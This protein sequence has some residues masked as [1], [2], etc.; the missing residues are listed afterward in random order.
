M[1][2]A[3]GIGCPVI[4]SIT[5]ATAVLV[6]TEPTLSGI[7]DMKRVVDL[8]AHFHI[9]VFVCINKFD[10]NPDLTSRVESY[11]REGRLKLA[12]KI[13]YDNVVT[14]AMVQGK[15]VVE[16]SSGVVAKEIEKLWRQI[17]YHL[18]EG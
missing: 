14:K 18:S 4:S 13:P 11:C 5:G 17:S 16:Y 3:P 10:L 9:P 1:D 2:G 7:H 6:V 15:T 12:G 8:A